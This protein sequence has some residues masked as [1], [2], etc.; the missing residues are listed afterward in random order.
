L[1]LIAFDHQHHVSALHHVTIAV[2]LG[3]AVG[4]RGAG[5][6]LHVD[7]LRIAAVFALFSF[8]AC[9][10]NTTT[11]DDNATLIIGSDGGNFEVQL[12]RDDPSHQFGALSASVD[13][14]AL[15]AP[16]ITAGGCDTNDPDPLGG[17]CSPATA[18]FEIAPAAFGSA[19]QADVTV[20]EDSDTFHFVSPD[21]FTPRAI[22]VQT[23][24]AQPLKLGETIVVSDGAASDEVSGWFEV[25]AANRRC[26]ALD[27][28]GAGTGSTR[29]N[30][31]AADY[32]PTC[33]AMAGTVVS[34]QVDITLQAVQAQA[35]D[36]PEQL[37]C[38]QGTPWLDQ[39]VA[40]QLQ[41]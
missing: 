16:T 33:D 25:W 8:A 6:A 30:L 24:L 3:C 4:P 10:T 13:G 37:I 28:L 23:S 12:Q 9:A 14:I 5:V 29:F 22:A 2:T 26:Y 36:G 34:A 31:D 15:G 1:A 38:S 21:F 7:M 35:C 11:T 41:L 20:T 19:A 32:D 27:S 17:G 40:M 18:T 39:T